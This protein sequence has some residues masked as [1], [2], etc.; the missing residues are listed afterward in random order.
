MVDA[1]SIVLGLDEPRIWA[2]VIEQLLE[3]TEGYQEYSDS[4]RE[5]ARDFTPENELSKFTEMVEV[6][7]GGPKVES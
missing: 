7:I 5:R 1:S 6:C 2:D 3:D 4:V